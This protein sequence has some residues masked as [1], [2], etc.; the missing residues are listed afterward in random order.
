MPAPFITEAGSLFTQLDHTVSK[1]CATM[2]PDAELGFFMQFV[3]VVVVLA[4]LVYL[5]RQL[6]GVPQKPPPS[7]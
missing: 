1:L 5:K 4:Y 6:P 3:C 2:S 7:R